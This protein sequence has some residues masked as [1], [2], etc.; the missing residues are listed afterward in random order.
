[1]P[2]PICVP[3]HLSSQMNLQIT[4]TTK[5]K[6]CRIWVVRTPYDTEFRRIARDWYERRKKGIIKSDN[7][8]LHPP[9]NLDHNVFTNNCGNLEYPLL[10]EA[11]IIVDKYELTVFNGDILNRGSCKVSDG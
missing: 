7:F 11:R 2:P 4:E 9:R 3:S 10:F 6:R 8:Q 5:Q 1:M